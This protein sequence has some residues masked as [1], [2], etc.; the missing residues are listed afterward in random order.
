MKVTKIELKNIL[1]LRELA[2]DCHGQITRIEGRNGSGKS[3]ALAGIRTAI[4]GGNLATLRNI[5]A[6]EDEAPEAVIVLDGDEHGTVIIE[7]KNAKLRVRKQVADSAAMEDVP[8]P[9]RFLDALFDGSASNPVKLLTAKDKELIDTLLEALP[10]EHD[11]DELWKLL[12]LDPKAFKVPTGL[13]PLKELAHVHDAIFEART[14]INRDEKAKRGAADQNRRKIPAEIPDSF[15]VGQ[16]EDHLIAMR[17]NIISRREQATAT[18]RTKKTA[19]QA[20]IDAHSARIEA[21]LNAAEERMRAEVAERLTALRAESQTALD[22]TRAKAAAEY[23][24]AD[25]E[26][27]LTTSALETA[28]E[29]AQVLAE[30]IA[31]LREQEKAAIGLRVLRD[32]A[33]EYESEADELRALSRQY[34]D[35][36]GRLDIY[37]TRLCDNLPIK[38]LDISNGEIKVHGVPWE[39]LNTAQRI[40]LAVT[41]ATLRLKDKPFRPVIVDG[42][43][44]LDEEQLALLESELEAAGAQAF[45]ARVTDGDLKVGSK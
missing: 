2:V 25:D 32:Q 35:A 5:D 11:P 30:E 22:E 14:G 12:E 9:Q 29:A 20:M 6:P 43:E 15:D 27:A 42:A 36:L 8:A 34:T 31:G 4:G 28:T 24:S 26:L 44:A 23:M 39:Q 18:A 17:Q 41:V 7:K 16:K 19:A 40:R 1:G 38:G 45:I 3:S 13:H 10:L 37:K 33:D 21:E